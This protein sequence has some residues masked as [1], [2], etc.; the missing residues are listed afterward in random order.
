MN[1][2]T[3]QAVRWPALGVRKLPVGDQ[4]FDLFW[5]PGSSVLV[6]KMPDGRWIAS[7]RSK[8]DGTPDAQ[9]DRPEP[10][11]RRGE[12]FE[13]FSRVADLDFVHAELL[14]IDRGRR[15]PR[16]PRFSEFEQDQAGFRAYLKV[17]NEFRRAEAA[18]AGN[19]E[20]IV[21]AAQQDHEV[22]VN[23]ARAA[24]WINREDYS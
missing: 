23:V 14:R 12:A 17:W 10:W 16:W 4:V 15:G 21:Q 9:R 7:W 1:A 11:F 24:G 18:W 3:S 22:A 2:P 5:V 8:P 20:I 13:E 19:P 6:I